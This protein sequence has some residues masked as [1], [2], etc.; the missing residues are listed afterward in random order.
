MAKT[1]YWQRYGKQLA[2]RDGMKCHY[3]GTWVEPHNDLAARFW[4]RRGEFLTMT[5]EE[6][7]YVLEHTATVDHLVPKSAGGSNDLDN[8][9]I[10]CHPCNTGRGAGRKNWA[11]ATVS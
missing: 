10:A 11:R 2:E 5:S 4:K 7:R 3:C 9:V 1:T 6:G 8:L